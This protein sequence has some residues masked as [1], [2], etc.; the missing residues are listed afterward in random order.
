MTC[1]I[2]IKSI[3]YWIYH[4]Q[5]SYHD[6]L[7]IAS[8]EMDPY[9]VYQRQRFAYHYSGLWC[10]LQTTL[11]WPFWLDVLSTWPC[12]CF[13]D[14][15]SMTI[16]MFYWSSSKLWVFGYQF[17]L[18]QL[19]YTLINTKWAGLFTSWIDT[20]KRVLITEHSTT[21]VAAHIVHVNCAS[22]SVVRV[23]IGLPLLTDEEKPHNARLFS[24]D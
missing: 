5:F 20:E 21:A 6:K 13:T 10:R 7:D 11:E 12:V 22:V 3:R 8:L 4:T 1:P 19:N 15:D 16:R 14:F 24:V 18:Y 17:V 2:A 23:C 9:Y